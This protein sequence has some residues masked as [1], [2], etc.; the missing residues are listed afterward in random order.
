MIK[1]NETK[2]KIDENLP[3]TAN[4]RDHLHWKQNFSHFVD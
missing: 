2:K 4:A 3:I 1:Q